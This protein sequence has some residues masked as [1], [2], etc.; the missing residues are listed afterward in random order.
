VTARGKTM[1]KGKVNY[2]QYE[3]IFWDFVIWLMKGLKQIQI[4]WNSLVN[5]VFPA[6]AIHLILF[7]VVCS[8][9]LGIGF[10]LGFMNIGLPGG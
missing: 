10:L 1:L 4:T 5:S 8:L 6:I 9:G 7:L 2:A 3:I